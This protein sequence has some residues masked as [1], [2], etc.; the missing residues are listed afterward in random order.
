MK[1]ES[2][3]TARADDARPSKSQRKREMDAL[4]ALG[5]Q[6]LRLNAAQLARLDLP[7]S[8]RE[9]LAAAH[10]ITSHEGRRR[11]L[12]YIGRLMR[13]IDPAPLQQALAAATGASRAAVALMHRCERLRD[14]LLEDDAALTE[15]I[16]A[17]P[18]V[19]AQRLRAT[20]RAAR[21]ER[22]QGQP[23][24]HARELYRWLHQTLST[25]HESATTA[26]G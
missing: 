25:E 2:A 24:R 23:P 3:A 16:A 9:A 5:V 21:R 14:R 8:L 10:R 6:L 17:H 22:T 15:F 7:E 12:Q 13:T 26:S 20:I 18:G 19:D 1:S 4:Q 11:Q